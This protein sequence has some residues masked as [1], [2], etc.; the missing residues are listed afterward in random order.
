MDQQREAIQ[1]DLRGVVAGEVH[2]GT[3]ITQLYASDASLYEIRPLAVVRPTGLTDVVACVRYAAERGIPIHARGA[4]TGL[5]GE[6]LGPGIVLDF[7]HSMRRVLAVDHDTVTVQ[8]G[9][10]HGQLN[11]LLL[12][13]G[14]MFGPDPATGGVTTMGSVLALDGGGSRWL[15]Y[16]SA[17]KQVVSLQVVLADGEVIDATPIAVPEQFSDGEGTPR[18]RIA[19]RLTELIRREQAVIE[20]HRPRAWVNRSGYQLHDVLQHDP[21][22]QH[23]TLDLAR[24]IVGSEGTLGLMTQATVKTSSVPKFVGQALLFFERLE[25][26]ALAAR[27]AAACGLAACDLMD[28]RIL[29]LARDLDP[30]YAQVIP[31]EAEALLLVEAH[32][33]HETR[34]RELVQQTVFAWRWKARWAFD[35]FT[36]FD[37]E[38]IELYRRLTR[39]VVPTLLRLKGSERPLPYVEDIAVP[40]DQLAD[41]FTRLQNCLK[42]FGI[43]ASVF[44]HAGHGQMHIRPFMDPHLPSHVRMMQDFAEALYEEVL[45]LGGTISGEHGAGLSRTWFLKRQYGPLYDVFREVKRI[46]DPQN[47]LNPGKVV[48]DVP[49]PLTKNLRPNATTDSQLPELHQSTGEENEETLVALHLHWNE[50]ELSSVAQFCNGCGRCRTQSPDYRMCPTFR[51][52][53]A[54]EASPRAKA[55]LLRGVLTGA[56]RTQELTTEE[57]KHFADLCVNCHQCQLECPAGVDIPRLVIE[58]KSQYVASNGLPTAEWFLSRIDW[59]AARASWFRPLANW[60]LGN[61]VARWCLERTIGIA[62]SRKLPRLSPQSFL[63]WAHRRRL[64][65]SLPSAKR[66]VLYFVDTY[67]NWFDCELGEALVA[68]LQH[69]GISVYVHPGQLASQMP[70]ITIGDVERARPAVLTNVKRLAEAVRQGYEIITT[71]PAAALCLREEYVH[72]IGDDDARLVAQHTFEATDYLWRMQQAGELELDFKPLNVSVG[73]HTPCH[74][75]VLAHDVPGAQLLKLIPGLTLER[76][77]KGCSGMAGIYGLKAD[78]FRKSV[79]IGFP[80]IAA[81]R[82]SRINLGVTE[83]ST[84]KLQMEQGTSK[85]TMHPLKLL[86]LSYGLM[87]HLSERLTQVSEELLV[88]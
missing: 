41:F 38:D 19:K 40:P 39:R 12:R 15:A 26:A 48:A 3:L 87:P 24:V 62:K 29:A 13:D 22:S 5:A 88:T 17:R 77:E 8:P 36:V 37:P 43:T 34:V 52:A 64:T 42:R 11:R 14:R 7:S 51:S 45:A 59:L 85:P 71:E 76:I 66:K 27:E 9:V 4:G 56:I 18:D 30:R 20:T 84:C 46:F 50:N 68:I 23:D 61:R 31:R 2:C 70:R 65:R 47:I 69:H 60:A 67:A 28:R 86:A 79:R 63:R 75:K 32:G 25:P 44:G 81:M 21:L 58:T 49:Q 83:C 16:G 80:L 55:N 57:A 6:S 82:E 72:L 74:M 1:A 10:V 53:P 78:N 35:A 33:E 73:Y 54:E